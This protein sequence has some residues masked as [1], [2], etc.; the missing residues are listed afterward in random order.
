[1]QVFLTDS[2]Y[3][4]SP[5]RSVLGSVQFKIVKSDVEKVKTNTKKTTD[6]IKLFG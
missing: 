4:S 2:C 6:D 3:Q 5:T 1:M